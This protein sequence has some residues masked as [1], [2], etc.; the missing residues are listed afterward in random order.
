MEK[1]IPIVKNI[2]SQTYTCENQKYFIYFPYEWVLNMQPGSGPKHCKNCKLHGIV[3][4]MFLGYCMDCAN[5]IYDFT[6]GH[7][8]LWGIE[9]I[10]MNHK[11]SSANFTYL[12]YTSASTVENKFDIPRF[13]PVNKV[14][15]KIMESSMNSENRSELHDMK[16]IRRGSI[17]GDSKIDL[18]SFTPRTISSDSI[19][20]SY[21]SGSYES[22]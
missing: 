9:Q 16:K 1:S 20:G 13:T 14:I 18:D 3:D 15:H 7:G 6:R 19:L 22:I 8:F 4:N 21:S 12:K 5:Y 2:D 17:G 11:E 10:D